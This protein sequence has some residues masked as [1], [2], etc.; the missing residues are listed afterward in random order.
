M[1]AVYARACERAGDVAGSAMA[2]AR[3]SMLATMR[4]RFEDA[5][6]LADRYAATAAS[7]GLPDA[8]ALGATLYAAIEVERG[9]LDVGSGLG[10][11]ASYARRRP[12]QLYEATVAFV[13][14]ATGRD[15]DARSELQRCL[16]AALSGT[17]PRWLRG[18]AELGVVAVWTDDL[19]AAAAIRRAL[20]PYRERIVVSGGAN[21]VL[22]P[23]ARY[24]GM[25]ALKLGDTDEAIDLLESAAALE[26]SIGALPGLANTS[27]LLAIATERRG[28]PGDGAR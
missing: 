16:P 7:A 14:A 5:A 6:A 2:T 19:A 15:G 25:L 3:A 24:L 21:A 10:V 12:G 22:G 23:A 27:A 28:G 1:L 17:G 11:L 9:T 4:G 18:M 8:D 20:L 13:L 26:T